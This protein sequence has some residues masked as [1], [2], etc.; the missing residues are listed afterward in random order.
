VI[1]LQV[2]EYAKKHCRISIERSGGGAENPILNMRSRGWPLARFS[3]S[4]IVLT[5]VFTG[6]IMKILDHSAGYP[7]AASRHDEQ[8]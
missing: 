8:T 5:W 2:D 3:H 6:L 1:D 4:F 7:N